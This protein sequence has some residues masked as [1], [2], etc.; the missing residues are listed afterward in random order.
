LPIKKK[1]ARVWRPQ[2]A[3][4]ET[5]TKS[6]RQRYLSVIK[7][8]IKEVDYTK[9]PN[10][11]TIYSIP[12]VLKACWDIGKQAVVIF[13]NS[14]VWDLNASRCRELMS[15]CAKIN[16]IY[17]NY[18]KTSQN[19]KRYMRESIKYNRLTQKRKFG[20]PKHATSRV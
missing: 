4:I 20:E 2:K 13:F 15:L 16:W 18:G 19:G 11:I 1:V 17:G 8:I 14:S 10:L 9:N 6:G 5:E 3:I 7:P 12:H